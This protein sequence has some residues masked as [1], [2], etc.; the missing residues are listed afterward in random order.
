MHHNINSLD[1]SI[2]NRH[3]APGTTVCRVVQADHTTGVHTRLASVAHRAEPMHTQ[4]V[5]QI[6]HEMQSGHLFIIIQISED[7]DNRK[8]QKK[9][10]E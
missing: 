4:H 9:V 2:L 5:A 1:Y 8:T 3:G 6:L 7:Y 10:G